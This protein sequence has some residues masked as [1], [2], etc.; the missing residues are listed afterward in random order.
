MGIVII[1]EFLGA[2][3]YILTKEDLRRMKY[4][5]KE[6]PAKSFHDAKIAPEFD[7]PSSLPSVSES[8]EQTDSSQQYQPSSEDVSPTENNDLSSLEDT[9]AVA[10]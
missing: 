4:E 10:Q 5:K 2:I 3:G 9:E 6:G 8:I 1:F 7:S